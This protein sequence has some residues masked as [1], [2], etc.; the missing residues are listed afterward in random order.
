MIG[1]NLVGTFVCM[2][3]DVLNVSALV[4]SLSQKL[5]CIGGRF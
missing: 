3:Q 5:Y 2:Q 1:K 4:K